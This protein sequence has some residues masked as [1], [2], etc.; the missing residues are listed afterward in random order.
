[1]SY[2]LLEFEDFNQLLGYID[3]RIQ[4][5]EKIQAMLSNRYEELS[6]KAERIKRLEEALSQL[7]GKEVKSIREIDFMGLRV[8]VGARV[9]DEL[10]VIDEVLASVNDTL[11]ALRKVRE[12]IEQLSKTVASEEGGIGFRLLVETVNGIPVRILLKEA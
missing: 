5:L 12:V 7:V 2:S 4:D 1:V 9:V 6:V 3:A 11:A 8:V 10:N